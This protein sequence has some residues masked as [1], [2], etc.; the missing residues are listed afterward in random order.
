MVFMNWAIR[1]HLGKSF[2]FDLQPVD[3]PDHN[4]HVH[5]IVLK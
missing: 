4:E 1:E 5:I 2:L 3:Q